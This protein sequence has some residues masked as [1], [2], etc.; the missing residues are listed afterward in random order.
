MC[1]WEWRSGHACAVTLRQRSEVTYEAVFL[2]CGFWKLR[3][4]YVLLYCVTSHTVHG[5]SLLHFAML[6]DC[7][8]EQHHWNSRTDFR[9]GHKE[10]A[11]KP[12]SKCCMLHAIWVSPVIGSLVSFLSAQVAGGME[13]H[14]WGH[15]LLGDSSWEGTRN[16]LPNPHPPWKQQRAS[17]FCLMISIK[18]IKANRELM[19]LK[20][21]V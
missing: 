3:S 14:L 13:G 11:G 12:V 8:T 15:P 10:R 4:S 6:C 9:G 5:Q 21:F 16:H 17:R 1:K 20:H 18:R 7:H 19:T 2:P